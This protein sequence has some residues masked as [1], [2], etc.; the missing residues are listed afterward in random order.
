[1]LDGVAPGAL[2]LE[3][4]AAGLLVEAASAGVRAAGHA[5]LPGARRLLRA[6]ER[7]VVRGNA[8]ALPVEEAP[9]GARVGSTRVIASGLLRRAADRAGAPPGPHLLVLTGPDAGQ[10]LPLGPEQTLGRSR[11]ATLRLA[12]PRASRLHARLR[13]D[14]AGA[15]VEDLGARN[16]LRVN[17]VP[18]EA[19]A[20][21]LLPGDVLG[22]GE[23]ELA[24]V[25]P[26]AAGVREA[27]AELAAAPE[28][29]PRGSD[30]RR[31]AAALLALAALAL[32]LAGA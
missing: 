27:P 13:V 8:L 25:V 23:T 32:A 6:G 16:G 18:I 19:R 2:R 26:W 31:T 17:G 24:L 28:A 11:R 14:D 9:A 15:T 20:Q 12:D 5:L 30:L 4:C 10:R 3:P 7:V 1:M 21:P 29:A 22:V